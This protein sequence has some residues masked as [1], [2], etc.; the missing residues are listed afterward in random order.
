LLTGRWNQLIAPLL[1]AVNRFVPV[2]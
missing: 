2:L 1:R